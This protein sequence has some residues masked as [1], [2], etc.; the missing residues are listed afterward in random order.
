MESYGATCV[1]VVDRAGHA[2]A[3]YRRSCR[4]SAPDT[5]AG[6]RNR[7]P[8]PPQPVSGVANSIVAVEHGAHRA[9]ASLTGM[10]AG[11]G[12]APLEVFVAAATRMG[13][14]HACD[15]HALE[16]AA[17]DLVRPLQDRPVRVDRET[18]PSA[19]PACTPAFLRHAEAVAAHD[20]DARS[21]L[22]EAGRRGMVGGQEDML[23]D[24]AAWT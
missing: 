19:M 3:R 2:D 22:E 20:I 14:S 8:R 12:N 1:Y 18:S 11:A 13:W 9:D 21:L 5:A 24:I 15:L 17:E 16:D 6:N 7:N 4:R 10:G 23:V